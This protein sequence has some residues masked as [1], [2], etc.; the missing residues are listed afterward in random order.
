MEDH[1]VATHTTR[2]G[3]WGLEFFNNISKF[4]LARV[5]KKSIFVSWVFFFLGGGW[6]DILI[7]FS[8][9]TPPKKKPTHP[10][11]GLVFKKNTHNNREIFFGSV[12]VRRLQELQA[13]GL[14]RAIL[15]KVPAMCLWKPVSLICTTREIEGGEFS[16]GNS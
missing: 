1:D 13:R 14:D 3:F 4:L 8:D 7:A 9:D 5:G 15:R 12:S 6:F 11:K 2:W 16:R 10:K